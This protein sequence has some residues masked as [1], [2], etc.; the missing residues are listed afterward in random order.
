MTLE[1]SPCTAASPI[2]T[3]APAIWCVALSLLAFLACAH[4]GVL[5]CCAF[6]VSVAAAVAPFSLVG[7]LVLG[8]VLAAHA[9]CR[10]A[11]RAVVVLTTLA[12]V[13]LACAAAGAFYDF[14]WDG[15]WYHQTAVY[16]IAGGWNPIADPLREFRPDIDLW[17]RHYAKGPWYIAVAIFRTTGDIECAKAAPWIALAASWLAVAAA[18]LEFGWS[19]RRAALVATL[20]ALNP[21]VLCELA[22]FLVD[23]LMVSFLA[24]FV[25][26]L[27]AW[28]RERTTL[29]AAVAMVAAILC[30]NAK[31]TG[32]VYVG[33]TMAAGGLVVLVARRAWLR[34]YIL[35]HSATLVIGAIGFGYNPYVTN[36]VARG[37]PFFPWSGSAAHPGF[38]RRDQDPNERFETPNNLIGRNRVYR[39]AYATF[40][41]PGAQPV[42]GGANAQ[43]MLPFAFRWSDLRMYR[44][45][46]LRLGGFGPL[47]SGALLVAAAV[48]L[49]ARYRTRHSVLL[50][51]LAVATIVASLL[52]GVQT[53]WARYAPQLWWLPIVAVV[54]GLAARSRPTRA[55]AMLIAVL[56]GANLALV[57]GAHFRWEIAATRAERAQFAVLQAQPFVEVNLQ[58]F[59]EPFAARL[60]TAGISFR[61]TRTLAAR[62]VP[63]VEIMSVAPGYPAPVQAWLPVAANFPPIP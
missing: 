16:Q 48:L 19:R 12:L 58:F 40:A 62:G 61:T 63:P 23:G 1:R 21:V 20:V 54:A 15:L 36:T 14:G 30:V 60:R 45:H 11:I 49:T 26:A 18:G 56:I 29:T 4:L 57:A 7:A 33:L 3:R 10:P 59:S 17:V 55:A 9:G 50:V 6:R 31:L 22:S 13:V 27:A 39:L 32:L 5:L 42:T 24:C 34:S 46:G 37:N 47:F 35:L 8:D 52:I 38:T 25:A 2:A 53:W 44:I 28:L 51:A 41:R 43:L